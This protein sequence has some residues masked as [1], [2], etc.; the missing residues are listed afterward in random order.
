MPTYI[1]SI[2]D[3]NS[4]SSLPYKYFCIDQDDLITVTLANRLLV[5]RVKQKKKKKGWRWVGWV[6]EES[7]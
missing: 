7:E 2:Y 4:C 6:V 1:V 5:D 3:L